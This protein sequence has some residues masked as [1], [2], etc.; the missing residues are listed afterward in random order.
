MH[1]YVMFLQKN[2]LC[3][4]LPASENKIQFTCQRERPPPPAAGGTLAAGALPPL[5]PAFRLPPPLFW[6]PKKKKR[7]S[8]ENPLKAHSVPCTIRPLIA[9][10]LEPRFVFW[11]GC[12]AAAAWACPR[13]PANSPRAGFLLLCSV[14]LLPAFPF[15]HL[16]LLLFTV[17]SFSFFLLFSFVC[18]GVLFFFFSP[19][20][21]SLLFC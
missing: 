18:V 2:T 21:F 3:N 14:C 8:W 19:C 20:L 7:E 10:K 4:W 12:R 15:L 5:P 9:V 16:H 1:P 6:R 17:F 13:V 11:G